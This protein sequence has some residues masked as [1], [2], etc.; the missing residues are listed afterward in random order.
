VNESSGSGR[1][2]NEPTL[3]ER[4]ER[5]CD[6]FESAWRAGR[7]ARIEDY[8]AEVPAVA[9]PEVFRE[10]LTL[11]IAY[12]RL[13]GETPCPEDYETRFPEHATVIHDALS[14]LTVQRV[15]VPGSRDELSGGVAPSRARFRVLRHHA[16]G[17]LGEVYVAQDEELTREVALK[18]MRNEIAHD[19]Q[20]RSRFLLEA[21]ITGALEHPGVVPVYALGQ[22]E[23]GRPY[24]VMR[25]I[26]GESLKEAIARFHAPGAVQQPG[27]RALEFRKLLGRFLDACEAIAYAHSR[28]VLHRDIKPANIMLGPYGE[29]LVVDWGLA[30]PLDHSEKSAEL[31]EPPL[32]PSSGSSLEP[33]EA[34]TAMGTP[35][36]MSPEQAAGRLDQLGGASD[37]YGLGATLY[38]L[39][40]GQPP[41]WGEHQASIFRKVI[42]GEI[43]RPCSVQPRIP[44]ALEAVCLKAMAL[45]PGDRY[46]SPRALA[47][48]LE[49]WLADEPVSAHPEPWV[50]RL[51]RWAR[52]H[53]PLV[54]GAAALLVT[55]VVAL[56]IGT[57]PFCWPAWPPFRLPVRGAPLSLDDPERG[58]ALWHR[59]LGC[60]DGAGAAAAAFTDRGRL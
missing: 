15:A 20:S 12:R 35:A 9:R 46:L 41:V 16:T 30:K 10:L 7:R 37:V 43:P 18:E 3:I 45:E 29:T 59:R 19:P 23:D 31:A 44:P 57:H 27:E 8:V 32:Q 36:Y 48:D 25:F 60:R 42:A 39:L 26:R 49:H 55:A 47:D 4:L 1:D 2:S 38:H 53:R 28:G 33:T 34:G 24:Y 11:E 5:M 13:A 6:G 52:R 54:T 22:Y 14:E 58:R 17:G 50:R 40:T 51:G 21:E 56:S